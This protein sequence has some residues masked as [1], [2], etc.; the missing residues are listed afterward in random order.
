MRSASDRAGWVE[1]SG[2]LAAMGYA[3]GPLT[4]SHPHPCPV[5]RPVMLPPDPWEA[6]GRRYDPPIDGYL[7]DAKHLRREQVVPPHL[8]MASIATRCLTSSRGRMIPD[9]TRRTC[10]KSVVVSKRRHDARLCFFS[11]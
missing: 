6:R 2:S 8:P 1:R 11:V 5:Q 10:L 3:P 9:G 7:P 4:R